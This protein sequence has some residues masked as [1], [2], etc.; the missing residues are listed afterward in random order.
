MTKDLSENVNKI[1]AEMEAT[2]RTFT[3]SII[4]NT[5]QINKTVNDSNVNIN[6]AIEKAAKDSGEVITQSMDGLNQGM[7]A[8]LEGAI[9]KLGTELASLSR[10]FVDDY[11]P[12]TESITE[13]IRELEKNRGRS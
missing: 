2:S 10:K 1:G 5:N 13:M 7:E 9:E 11:A 12:L 4:E 3:D 6:A 8:A